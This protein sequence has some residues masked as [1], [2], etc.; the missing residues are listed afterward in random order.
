MLRTA[1]SITPEGTLYLLFSVADAPAVARRGT[2]AP[3]G[4]GYRMTWTVP[5]G[6]PELGSAT[7]STDPAG[8]SGVPASH[9]V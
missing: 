2:L 5:S 7:L 4:G 1:G 3:A 8:E 9:G 6:G